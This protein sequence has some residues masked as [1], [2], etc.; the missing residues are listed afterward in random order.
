M[1]GNLYAKKFIELAP[2]S[3][4]PPQITCS[5]LGICSRSECSCYINYSEC[6]VCFILVSSIF[7]VI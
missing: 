5:D 1:Q 4:C 2:A 7:E 3:P 6:K